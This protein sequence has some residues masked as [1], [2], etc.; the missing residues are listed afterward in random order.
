MGNAKNGAISKSI[1]QRLIRFSSNAEQGPLI[2]NDLEFTLEKSPSAVAKGLKRRAF[3]TRRTLAFRKLRPQ[4][5]AGQ[6]KGIHKFAKMPVVGMTRSM[7][8][9]PT[10]CR[11]IRASMPKVVVPFV[12]RTIDQDS[13]QL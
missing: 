8:L 5:R 9:K 6:A 4:N 10:D 2:W 11:V 7:L 13:I 12:D 3:H 1:R